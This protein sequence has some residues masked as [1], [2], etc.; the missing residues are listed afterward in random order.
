MD[1][2]LKE[3]ASKWLYANGS[4]IDG[5][6]M[7]GVTVEEIQKHAQELLASFKYTILVNG[8]LRRDVRVTMFDP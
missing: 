5:S 2:K 1:E 8:N 4:T 3:I 6:N 7:L